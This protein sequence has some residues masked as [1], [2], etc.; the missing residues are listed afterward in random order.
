MIK[1][2]KFSRQHL[3]IAIVDDDPDDRSLLKK[4]VIKVESSTKVQCFHNGREFLNYLLS[5][6][7]EL[8]DIA[9]IDINMPKLDGFKTT[10]QIKADLNLAPI[11]VLMFSTSKSK[12]DIARA[13][14]VKANGYIQKPH[15]YQELLQI[16]RNILRYDWRESCPPYDFDNFVFNSNNFKN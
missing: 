8:P 3:K 11:C 2:E 9:L 5:P 7:A 4:A 12:K 6:M 10:E 1:E 14:T 13:I 16:C 15:N